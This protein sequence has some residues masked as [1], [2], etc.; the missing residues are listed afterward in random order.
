MTNERSP[1]LISNA[2]ASA[3]AG[4]LLVGSTIA[5]IG[6]AFLGPSLGAGFGPSSIL[7]LF[8]IGS[9]FGVVAGA[10]AGADSDEHEAATPTPT[11]K[12][13]RRPQPAPTP[14]ATLT[15]R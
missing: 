2:M 4:A 8:V 15:A 6:V 5:V 7:L 1:K 9:I 10:V 14:V 11:S 12:K 3:I 13:L